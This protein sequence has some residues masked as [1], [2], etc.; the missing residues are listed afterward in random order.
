[1]FPQICFSVADRLVAVQLKEGAWGTGAARLTLEAAP[2]H[3]RQMASEALWIVRIIV[4]FV[5]KQP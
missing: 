2:K 3:M 4:P 1:V 5:R